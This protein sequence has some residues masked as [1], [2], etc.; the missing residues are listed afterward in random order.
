MRLPYMNEF[1][2]FLKMNYTIEYLINIAT[3]QLIVCV[4]SDDALFDV[5]LRKCAGNDKVLCSMYSKSSDNGTL[6]VQCQ[7]SIELHVDAEQRESGALSFQQHCCAQDR[8]IEVRLK[9]SDTCV[10]RLQA[11]E[12][13]ADIARRIE[14]E[15]AQIGSVTS[16]H[17]RFC[18][19]CLLSNGSDG[20]VAFERVLLMP[21]DHWHELADMW[22]CHDERFEQFPRRP[23]EA[24]PRH[25]LISASAVHVHLDDL[26]V[27]PQCKLESFVDVA[28]S[29]S[30]SSLLAVVDNVDRPFA[31]LC[32]DNENKESKFQWTAMRCTRC[33]SCVGV[34]DGDNVKL[35]K[36]MIAA[37]PRPMPIFDDATLES[38]CAGELYA[39]AESHMCYHFFLHW[40]DRESERAFAQVRVLNWK[41]R[42][43]SSR[44]NS[45][46][47]H[48][49]KVLYHE[50]EQG[51]PPT[52]LWQSGHRAEDIYVLEHEAK[53]LVRV[54]NSNNAMLPS[55]RQF[56]KGWRL[57]FLS[58]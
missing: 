54:L 9:M 2:C 53:Q 7:E 5:R 39:S 47:R 41:T 50:G 57:S 30:S 3:V 19:N 13:G 18:S 37:L 11:E 24:R 26:H 6:Q 49:L 17:C 12:S 21:S 31:L 1:A 42:L 14:S 44:D 34:V 32:D 4:E 28:S 10:Q 15:C 35:Y 29:S 23:L 33:M 36:Y 25:C 40:L 55:S 51:A 46:I 48:V 27:R 43:S 56:F 16:L 22:V 38:R 8:Y 52:M 20:C 58:L 45:S